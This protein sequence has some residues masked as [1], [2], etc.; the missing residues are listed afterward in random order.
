MRVYAC[1]LLSALDLDP[2]GRCE[3]YL[4]SPYFLAAADLLHRSVRASA[5]CTGIFRWSNRS[6]VAYC[7]TYTLQ[8][9]TT[10][11]LSTFCPRS[12]CL[13]DIPDAINATDTGRETFEALIVLVQGA[14]RLRRDRQVQRHGSGV[15]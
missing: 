7:T 6:V 14:L 10:N 2:S 3:V 5:A 1:A 13:T 11:T 12:E 4:P 8:T 15:L 9:C